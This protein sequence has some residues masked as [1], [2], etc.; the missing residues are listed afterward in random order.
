ML[1]KKME[2]RKGFDLFFLNFLLIVFVFGFVTVPVHE[3]CRCEPKAGLQHGKF[4]QR[5]GEFCII[6]TVK[7]LTSEL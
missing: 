4:L 2:V 3:A 6:F 1:I 5:R 7:I